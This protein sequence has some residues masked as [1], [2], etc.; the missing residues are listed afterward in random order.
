VGE[1]RADGP[2]G[3]GTDLSERWDLRHVAAVESVPNPDP[4]TNGQAAA[5]AGGSADGEQFPQHTLVRLDAGL[6]D[7]HTAPADVGVR[8]MTFRERGGLFGWNAPD[9]RVVSIDLRTNSDLIV[10]VNSS[11]GGGQWKGFSLAAD[12]ARNEIGSNVLDLD[13]EYAAIVPGGWVCLQSATEVE[14]F[15]VERANP[16]ARTDFSLTARVTRVFLDGDENLDNFNRRGTSVLLGSEELSM[17]EPADDST[18]AGFVIELDRAVDPLPAGRALLV[19]GTAPGSADETVIETAVADCQVVDSRTV[20]T[21]TSKLP[22]LTRESVVIHANVVTAT[23][24]ETV[25]DEVL[26]HGDA[27][28]AFQAFALRQGP[29]S[30]IKTPPAGS[31][32]TLEVRVGGVRWDRVDTLFGTGPRDRVYTVRR[33]AAG[34]TLVGFGDGVSGARLPSGVE[35]VRGTYRKGIGLEGEVGP[36]QLT[37]LRVRPP[38]LRG[39]TNPK[40]AGG[41]GDPASFDDI[42]RNAPRD[43]LTLGRLVSLQDYEDF[44]TSFPSVGKAKGSALWDGRRGFVH[45]T[46]ASSSGQVLTDD[47]ETVETLVASIQA[48][49]DP[50]HRVLVSGHAPAF[51]GIDVAILVDPARL[52]A[53][54]IAATVAAITESFGFDRREFAQP[55]FASEVVEV[56]QRTDGVV[57]ADLDH[58]YRTDEAVA[59]HAALAAAAPLWDGVDVVP[60][61]LLLVSVPH[62]HVSRMEES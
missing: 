11:G 33:D 2:H 13:R 42:R 31:E 1:A 37:L 25:A 22:E 28:S 14:L 48:T 21:L 60:A 58:L 39:V 54:V 49:K 57:A 62:I 46:V 8:V 59:Y 27:G 34:H 23:H 17:A 45:L 20:L 19:T 41:A 18:V 10:G 56:V 43:V 6:G 7:E 51:F 40:G 12:R 47:D 53:E 9:A 32:S 50:A 30:W 5:S 38:G 4:L 16:A 36:D 61:E 52:A 35:N 24:G 29:L 3:P 44:A 55:V 26:G 15:G